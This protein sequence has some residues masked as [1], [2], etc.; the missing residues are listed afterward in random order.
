M[1]FLCRIPNFYRMNIWGIKLITVNIFIWNVH[2]RTMPF[3][4]SNV[5]FHIERTLVVYFNSVRYSLR[6]LVNHVLGILNL[7]LNCRE[8]NRKQIK[9]QFHDRISFLQP[10]AF[11]WWENMI[12]KF[13]NAKHGTQQL[14]RVK[15]MPKSTDV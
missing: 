10:C 12:N 1:L 4:T 8:V 11:F 13:Q 3:K 5:C 7:T 2:A 15:E 9:K 6:R 14:I